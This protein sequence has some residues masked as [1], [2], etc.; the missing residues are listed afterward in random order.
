METK[1]LIHVASQSKKPTDAQLQQLI[2]PMNDI[3]GQIT[4]LKD[5]SRSSPFYSNLCMV[6]DGSPALGWVI[7]QPT[8]SPYVKEMKDAANFYANRVV[9]ENKDKNQVHLDWVKAFMQVL[10][11][12]VGYVKQYHTTGLYWNPKGGD[13]SSASK[14]APS[15]VASA[16]PAQQQ[17][18]PASSGP[19]KPA[20][21]IS[22]ELGKG[23]SGLKKVDKSQMTHK[24]PELRNTSVV[25]ATEKPI[26]NHF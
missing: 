11:E 20:I 10:D 8:P 17:A 13:A 22:A 7:V 14:A 6:A 4:A 12:L 5:S 24:N 2:K 26:G 21:D 25:K 9:K 15:V 23:T 1:N 3:I 18:A 16:A 19:A